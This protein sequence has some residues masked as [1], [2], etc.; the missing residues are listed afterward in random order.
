[1]KRKLDKFD[2]FFIDLINSRMKTKK[3]DSFMYIV[4]NLGGVVF[5]SLFVILTIFLGRNK[6]R[7]MGY[8]MLVALMISQSIVYTLKIVL[9]RERP[10]KIIEHLNTFGIEM[11]DYSFPSGHSSG[12]FSLATI[13]SLNFSNLSIYA[14]IIATM[15]AVSRI[16]LGVHY[17]T[18]VVAGMFLG[19]ISSY[20]V[21]LYLLDYIISFLDI[22][23]V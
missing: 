14:Y 5:T 15:I 8:E 22:I 7:Y 10:Y 3:L 23:S 16:Y 11:K 13:I 4:T 18:D 1:M 17:P 21:H 12:S 6:F 20:I 9:S 19:I 2:N